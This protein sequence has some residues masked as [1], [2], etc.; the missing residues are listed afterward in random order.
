MRIRL[1]RVKWPCGPPKNK[2][3]TQKLLV[4]RCFSFSNRVFAGSNLGFG[5]VWIGFAMERCQNKKNI[6]GHWDLTKIHVENVTFWTY[7]VFLHVFFLKF[8]CLKLKFLAEASPAVSS[9]DPWTWAPEAGGSVGFL[10]LRLHEE[11]IDI[12]VGASPNL[13]RKLNLNICKVDG[14]SEKTHIW[15]RIL[16]TSQQNKNL[17]IIFFDVFFLFFGQPLPEGFT[18][19]LWSVLFF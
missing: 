4:C 16:V 18:V 5:D 10:G 13:G 7:F 12:L 14:I 11:Y 15:P 6:F 3:E 9:R 1:G 2:H 8:T 17:V 19:H